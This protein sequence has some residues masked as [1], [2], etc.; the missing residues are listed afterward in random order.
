MLPRLLSTISSRSLSG[1]ERALRSRRRSRRRTCGRGVRCVADRAVIGLRCIRGSQMHPITISSCLLHQ[2]TVG[3]TYK[4]SNQHR[5]M[6]RMYRLR[7]VE[8]RSYNR[9]SAKRA[10]HRP[11]RSK[12]FPDILPLLLSVA[13]KTRYWG[14]QPVKRRRWKDPVEVA[15]DIEIPASHVHHVDDL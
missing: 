1:T 12:N 10:H 13:Q 14:G 4:R 11:K 7:V 8:H 2:A 15:I 6:M 9:Q 3:N 5:R